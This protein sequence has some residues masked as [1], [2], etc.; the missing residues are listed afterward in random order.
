MCKT[1]L[2]VLPLIRSWVFPTLN[3][4]VISFKTLLRFLFIRRN[5]LYSPHTDT[6]LGRSDRVVVYTLLLFLKALIIYLKVLSGIDKILEI[7][8]I[9][10]PSAVRLMITS[11]LSGDNPFSFLLIFV[12]NRIKKL[13]SAINKACLFTYLY[14]TIMWF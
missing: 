10:Y 3:S 12:Y 8:L 6:F 5:N 14:P 9:L 11:L 13:T 2:T 7:Y 4:L 1:C